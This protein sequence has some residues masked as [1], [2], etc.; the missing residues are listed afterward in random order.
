MSDYTNELKR[1]RSYAR[2]SLLGFLVPIVWVY[3][4][5]KTFR[6]LSNIPDTPDTIAHKKRSKIYLWAGLALLAATFILISL[7]PST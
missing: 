1:A 5:P 4:M 3:V 6:L 2:A 7:A